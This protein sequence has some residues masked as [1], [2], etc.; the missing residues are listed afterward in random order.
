MDIGR[1][2]AVA[3]RTRYQLLLIAVVGLLAYSNTFQTPF[4]FDDLPNI[5]DIPLIKNIGNFIS[6]S[7]GYDF[8]PRRFAGYLSFAVNYH[9]GGLS[10]TGYHIVN[11]AIHITSAI[12]VYLLVTLTFQTPFMSKE[13]RAENSMPS[14]LRPM[15][16]AA[17]FSAL[18]FVAHPI[19]TQAVT[20]IVQRL[21]SLAAMFYLL[22]LI[23]YI[24]ARLALTTE[25]T[26]DSL[27]IKR[28]QEASRNARRFS[29]CSLWL[30]L[31]FFSAV[32]AMK[33]KETAFTLPVIIIL[34]EFTFFKS[35][36]KKKLLFLTPILFTML[37]IPISIMGTNRPLSEIISDLSDRFR[38]QTDL[39]RWDYLM[40]QMRVITTYVRLIFL[41]VN[42]RLDYNYPVY[43]SLFQLPVLLSF[44]FL[45][46]I[47]GTGIY[48]LQ[49]AKSIEQIAKTKDQKGL[50][51]TPYA[52][53]SLRLI[54]FGILWFFMTLSV[55]SGIIPIADVIFEHRLYLSSAGAFIAV[56]ASAFI[57]PLRDR[58]GQTKMEKA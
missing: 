49:R 24:K 42:Q 52:L 20:Y 29:L 3:V 13:Q 43:H 1:F 23:T 28:P 6:S 31:S 34:Y 2:H 48:M 32:L 14:A 26:E 44:I 9:F 27:N 12:L 41:P 17:L 19:Q 16:L 45:A 21:A 15:R 55:E 56:A 38:L 51:F 22:S 10:V 7:K 47:F 36:L 37:I 33:T 40:T 58:S 30:I 39:S 54:G 46:S 8:N 18:L 57:I 50:Y 25:F 53:C 5:V 4:Q 11:L 35:T